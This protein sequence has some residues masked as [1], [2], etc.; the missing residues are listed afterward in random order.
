MKKTIISGVVCTVLGA[1]SMTIW[2]DD[3]P[4]TAA[5]AAPAGPTAMSTPSMTF[6]LAANPTPLSLDAGPL[7]N[8]YITGALTGLGLTQE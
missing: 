4:A 5:L 8:V 2:A 1:S 3:Q 6:P 7:G